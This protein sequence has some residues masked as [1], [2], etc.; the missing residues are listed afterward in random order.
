MKVKFKPPGATTQTCNAT[1]SIPWGE[2]KRP[3]DVRTAEY[4]YQRDPVYDRPSKMDD[5]RALKWEG[6]IV[7]SAQRWRSGN[8][9]EFHSSFLKTVVGGISIYT[10]TRPQGFP[11]RYRGKALGL[12]IRKAIV[13]KPTQRQR[14]ELLHEVPTYIKTSLGLVKFLCF[15][16]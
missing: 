5:V 10:D 6:V 9:Y 14:V 7:I 12:E 2:T 8:C 16:I 3:L 11:D 4:K 1:L 13:Q 15:E